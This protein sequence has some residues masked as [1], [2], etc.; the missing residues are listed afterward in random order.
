[1]FF[2]LPA[3][4]RLKVY[5]AYL[6]DAR[7]RRTLEKHLH[8]DK[9]NNPCCTWRWPEDLIICDRYS[10]N[11]L[12]TAK[13]APWLPILAFANKQLLGEVTVFML[14]TTAWFDFKYEEHKPFK[15]VRW[16]TDFLSTFPTK[17]VDDVATTEGFAAIKRICFPHASKYNEHRVGRV[18]DEKN[19]DITL[20]LKCT[21]LETIA[22]VFN[23]RQLV[24]NMW[25]Q[26]P[27]DLEDFLDFFHFR[28]MLDHEGVE[29]VYLEGVY[30]WNG[31]GRT[32]VCLVM[33][34]K[35]IIKEFEKRGR[36][37]NVHIHKRCGPFVGR[38]VGPKLVVD[39][40]VAKA[41]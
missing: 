7:Q 2:D 29:N 31:E 8:V 13:Y 41:G 37:V 32:M 12:P 25:S 9:F 22:M 21:K 34:G 24:K 38:R 11:E 28:P 1:M 17:V 36:K 23:F 3:E 5:G 40:E 19:P 16:F 18:V 33:F 14:S 39:E 35:W 15:I 4:L 20:M 10:E 26:E 6:E 27:R 30:P